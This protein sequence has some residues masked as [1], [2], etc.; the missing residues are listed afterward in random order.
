MVLPGGRRD[1]GSLR[2]RMKDGAQASGREVMKSEW[3][4]DEEE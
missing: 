3:R 4:R 2:V 1:G